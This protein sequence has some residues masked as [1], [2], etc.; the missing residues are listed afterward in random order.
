MIKELANGKI[1]KG[2]IDVYSKKVFPIKINL[3]LK[4]VESVL[5]MSVS[6]AEATRILKLLDFDVGASLKVIVP[7][8]RQDIK[9]QEDLIEEIARII[10]YDNIEARQPLG[11]LG[12]N[13][14][15]DV[16]TITN[17]VKTMLEGLGFTEVYNFSFVGEDD[18]NKTKIDR[19]N[20]I[21][22][23]NPLSVDLK[24]L[25]KDLII[26]LLKNIKDNYKQVLGGESLI[27][28]FELGKTYQEEG[29]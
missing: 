24:Y 15:D 5:G 22:L 4:K 14:L 28:I 19:R 9:I 21:E 12:I 20:Y 16:L 2:T 18:L 1:A 11:F 23:E 6:K 17:K 10:G 26:N 25:R 7:T 27:K 8:I 29:D 13:K 3:D